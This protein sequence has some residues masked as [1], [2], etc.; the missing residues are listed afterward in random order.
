MTAP[1]TV[2]ASSF[3]AAAVA[4]VVAHAFGLTSLQTPAHLATLGAMVATLVAA[5][6]DGLARHRHI[7]RHK[8]RSNAIR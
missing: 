8:E 1:L 6:A 7:R 5:I 3:A 2:A 4:D